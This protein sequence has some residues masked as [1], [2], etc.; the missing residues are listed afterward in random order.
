MKDSDCPGGVT[1]SGHCDQGRAPNESTEGWSD[2]L[3][4]GISLLEALAVKLKQGGQLEVSDING[5]LFFC[6]EGTKQTPF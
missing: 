1:G 3:P 4:V 5:I 6:V 2:L